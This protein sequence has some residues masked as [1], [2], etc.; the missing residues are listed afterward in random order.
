MDLVEIGGLELKASETLVEDGRVMCLAFAVLLSFISNFERVPVF[1]IIIFT[2]L[3]TISGCFH[4]HCL[5]KYVELV[6]K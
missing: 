4:T 1:K 2:G 3:Q 5:L 6:C